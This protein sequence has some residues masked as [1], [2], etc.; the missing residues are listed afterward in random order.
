MLKIT[1]NSDYNASVQSKFDSALIENLSD[2]YPFDRKPI[3][4]STNSEMCR[5]ILLEQ[6]TVQK[7]RC[8]N[9]IGIQK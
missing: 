9:N 5:E 1:I 3:K 2:V 6:R 8:A 4:S 7:K